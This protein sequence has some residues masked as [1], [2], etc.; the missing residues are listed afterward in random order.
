MPSEMDEKKGPGS[1]RIVAIALAV[2]IPVLLAYLFWRT[3]PVAGGWSEAGRADSAAQTGAVPAAPSGSQK[4]LDPA[5]LYRENCASCHGPTLEGTGRAPALRRPGWPYAKDRDS[6]AKVI[7]E[8]RG[9]RMPAFGNRLGDE[10]IG[11]LA[12]YLESA[13]GAGK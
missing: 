6:I 12:D 2:V 9:P 3:T 7:R 10:Q 13:N 5:L 1:G 4:I 8:G 11:L